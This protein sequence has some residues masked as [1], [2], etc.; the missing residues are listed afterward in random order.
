MD[1][2]IENTSPK[3]AAASETPAPAHVEAT[4]STSAA[5][6]TN[7][8]KAA[9]DGLSKAAETPTPFGALKRRTTEA[10]NSIPKPAGPP[11]FPQFPSIA[12]EL[13]TR[14][15]ATE[16]FGTLKRR[17]TETFGTLQRRTTN[18]MK[19][20]SV[21]AVPQ[22]PS[23]PTEMPKWADFS[24]LAAKLPKAP[25]G[26]PQQHAE[27]TLPVTWERIFVPAL[28]RSSH[29]INVVGGNAY[30][31]GGEVEP[32]KPV[33][34]D[35]HL[36]VLPYSSA[37]A[38]YIA[39]KPKAAP[40]PEPMQIPTVVEPT[41]E[42]EG[43]G[44]DVDLS[45]VDLA[46]PGPEGG[47][48]V[49]AG[50]SAN[51][52]ESAHT[53]LLPDNSSLGDVPCARVGHATA[54]IGHRIFLFGGRGGP[55]MAALEENGRVWVF[56]TKTNLWSFL[57]PRLPSTPAQ[58]TSAGLEKSHFPAARSYHSAVG[59]DLP[60]DFSTKR[61]NR[62]SWAQWAQG[63]S[64][65]LGTPQNPIV[66]YVADNS[67]DE[68]EDG[69][70]TL[71]VH[72][73]CFTEGRASDT[74]AFDVRSRVWQELPAAP[75]APRGGTSL[76]VASG[77]LWRFGGF[78]G[79]S[80]EGGQLDYLPLGIDSFDDRGGAADVVLSAKG[81]WKSI[82]AEQVAEHV[83]GEDAEAGDDEAADEKPLAKP[84]SSSAPWPGHRSVAGLQTVNNAG[85]EYLVLLLGE[86]DPSDD[87]H[88]AA[89]K[90]WD[91]VWA[92]E[93]PRPT[94][95]SS[96]VENWFGRAPHAGSAAAAEGK[97]FKVAAGAYDDEDVGAAKGPG[98]RGWFATAHMGQLEERGLVVWGGVDGENSRLGDGWILRVGNEKREG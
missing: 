82:L 36:I 90:F 12:S 88:N 79:E 55:D 43:K 24:G 32:R 22:V 10:W 46:S 85:R 57:D 54:V 7:N 59:V 74:W 58:P 44:K 26:G 52:K 41:A 27:L 23:V 18:L 65:T 6:A 83:S 89:G 3:E 61:N 51:G 92:Y 25:W 21:P 94:A 60:R 62:Q 42:E 5:P 76:A 17:T 50:S 98:P 40:R 34:N 77:K 71:V 47:E 31:F 63:D 69:F 97:W 8:P 86:R 45:D 19:G 91:D 68:D 4:E 87:G 38:D 11:E 33:D 20:V 35:M 70:G 84:A 1:P 48:E 73:G 37:D 95:A 56:D 2:T 16:T 80:E 81:E 96:F 75:G 39:I 28:P 14:E 66:G 49:L 93:L 30:I 72:G 53:S 29:S 78:N 13:P 67:R 64:E 15:S 9:V